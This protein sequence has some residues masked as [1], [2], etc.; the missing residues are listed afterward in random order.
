MTAFQMFLSA[1]PAPKLV[2][3]RLVRLYG[4]RGAVEHLLGHTQAGL[5]AF[6]GKELIRHGNVTTC[7]VFCVT[8]INCIKFQLKKKKNPLHQH[9]SFRL[10]TVKCFFRTALKFPCRGGGGWKEISLQPL[11]GNFP[12]ILARK[13]PPTRARKVPCTGVGAGKFPSDPCKEISLYGR[14]V[15]RKFPSNPL[16]SPQS[17]RQ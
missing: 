5:A 15:G 12:P 13:F 10:P 1:D 4:C 3:L 11:Q 14:G 17:V 9:S 7:F 2:E 8:R 16:L 6:S